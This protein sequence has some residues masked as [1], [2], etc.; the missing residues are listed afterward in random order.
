M[1]GGSVLFNSSTSPSSPFNGL[2]FE[3][4]YLELSTQL[5]SGYHLYGLGEEVLPLLRNYSANPIATLWARDQG[6]P[7]GTNLYGSHPFYMEMRPP[8]T[9]PPL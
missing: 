1:N 3:D 4:Q 2:I 7:V 6:T 5:P 9:A 8:G